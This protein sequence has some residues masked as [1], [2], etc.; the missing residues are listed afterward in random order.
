MTP[1]S[2]ACQQLHLQ[3]DSGGAQLQEGPAGDCTPTQRLQPHRHT[4]LPCG[5]PADVRQ[6]GE[7]RA[8]SVAKI[9]YRQKSG[10]NPI[11]G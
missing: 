11:F 9:R 5:Q 10:L 6:P 8:D 4:P 7:I 3:R 2:A 1:D